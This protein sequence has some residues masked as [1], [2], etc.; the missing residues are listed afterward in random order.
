MKSGV[1]LLLLILAAYAAGSCVKL[2]PNI[3]SPFTW[4][5]NEING[6]LPANWHWGNVNSTNFLCTT[7]NQHI[8]Q[9]CG[10]CWAQST[11]STISDRIA[12]MRGGVFPEIDISPQI[13]LTCDMADDGCHGGD[14]LSAY[15]WMNQ[16]N[17]T[18]SSCAPYLAKSHYEGLVCNATVMCMDCAPSGAC[19]VPKKYNNYRVG[20]YGQ[21][22]ALNAQAIQNEIYAR[23]PVTCCIDAGP[24]VNF[25][26]PGIVT[27]PG[28]SINHAIAV[29]GWG[30]STDGNNTPYWVVR[31]SWGEYW[32]DLGYMKVYRGNNT[33]LIEQYCTYGV[34]INTW[35]N[36][37]Y[38]HAPK[39]QEPV[40]RVEGKINTFKELFDKF[41]TSQ[42]P[43]THKACVIPNPDAKQVVTGPKPEDTVGAV[44]DNFWWGNDD[45]KNYLSWVVN[46]HLPQYCG[47]C[48]AQSGSSS[49]ADRI[50]ILNGMTFPRT[51]LA[52]QVL[53]NC[54]AGGSCN[55]GSLDGPYA[56]AHK[57][58]LPDMGCQV[59]QAMNPP[60]MSCTDIQ[61]C[62]NCNWGP[63]FS[64]NCWAITSYP[65]WGVSQYGPVRGPDGMKKEIFARG[66]ITCQMMVTNKFEN[67][68]TGGIYSEKT[69][70]V[71][72][73]HAISVTGWGKDP[74]SGESY[75]IVRNSWGTQFGENGFFRIKMGSDN[76]GIDSHECWWGV[77]VQK[78]SDEFEQIP[79]G[80]VT[81]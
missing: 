51:A 46:Q 4:K 6:P 72:P 27:A 32:G 74:T 66:P 61:K 2:N 18:D 75:W 76:L 20:E 63:N 62:K 45:G 41:I 53:I 78:M 49:L 58:G 15:Q 30:V 24:V 71:S 80:Y 64:V 73:N 25:T 17:I 50:N 54:N 8:P 13:L 69:L 48:W 12:I 1:A 52:P 57:Y 43:T 42:K 81:E 36:Q 10:S 22:P 29:V 70:F 77:P 38:P 28:Q 60:S 11:T 65:K 40:Q 3:K 21:L 37:S 19:N 47:S 59:Y 23:G 26:G 14:P 16:N 79:E 5:E 33:L 44:P 55:G 35:Q 7:K 39:P 34:P 68:Y 9:Y 56:F 31:N 67:T